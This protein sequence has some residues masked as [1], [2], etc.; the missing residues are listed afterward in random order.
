L[1]GRLSAG[2]TGTLPSRESRLSSLVRQCQ[3]RH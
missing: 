2:P 3:G 1:R